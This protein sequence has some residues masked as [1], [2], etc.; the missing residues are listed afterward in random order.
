MSMKPGAT[1]Q[2]DAS[3]SCSP[4][5]S[6][7]ISR[8]TPSVTATS[9]TRPGAPLPSTTVPPRMTISADITGS[10]QLHQVA[11]LAHRWP[12]RGAAVDRQHDPR[13]L[14]RALAR[15]VEHRV[16][17]VGRVAVALERL[18][19]LDHRAHVVVA[20]RGG[21]VTGRDAVDPDAEVGEI[22]GRGTAELE[23]RGLRHAVA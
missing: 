15:Q 1:T 6:G 18:G 3:S 7:P 23:D 21:D 11:Q 10:L 9:A 20:D 12:R 5:R 8:M 13:D 4:R 14:R 16:R 17:H 2:P 19:Q 22:D